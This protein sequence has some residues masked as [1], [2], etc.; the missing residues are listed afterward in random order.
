MIYECTKSVS[1]E[2][3]PEPTKHDLM[4]LLDT[5]INRLI[6]EKSIMLLTEELRKWI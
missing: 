1:V 6:H 2:L 3:Q 5:T 4:Q